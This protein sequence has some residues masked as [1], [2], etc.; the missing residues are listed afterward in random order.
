[1]AS[2][3]LLKVSYKSEKDAA[4]GT[5][6]VD[7]GAGSVQLREVRYSRY[8]VDMTPAFAETDEIRSD[9]QTV[10]AIMT[11]FGAAGQIEAPFAYLIHDDFI[12]AAMLVTSDFQAGVLLAALT[13]LTFAAAGNTITRASGDFVAAGIVAGGFIRITGAA[14]A[15]NNSVW[16]MT[17]VTTTVITVSGGTLVN[18]SAG[19]SVVIKQSQDIKPGTTIHSMMFEAQFTDLS[20]EYAVAT[21]MMV[22]RWALSVPTNGLIK[23]TFDTLGKTVASAS[24]TTGTGAIIAAPTSVQFSS[25]NNIDKVCVAGAVV[26]LTAVQF[27]LDNRLRRHLAIGTLGPIDLGMG[28][29]GLEGS[30][31][32][33]Y[34]SKADWD[35]AKAKTDSSLWLSFVDAANDRYVIEFPAIVYTSATRTAGG[36]DSDAVATIGFRA[37]RST[38]SYDLTMMRFSKIAP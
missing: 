34:A 31:E 32:A 28:S 3:A 2:G 29:I 1:M 18:E 9:R 11:D 27:T 24:A 23:Q 25:V 15:G 4:G 26:S 30:F 17:N 13:N 7:P 12:R 22:S 8:G 33:Y 38:A 37:K 6:G 35:K 16:K 21:G 5:Y 10:D 14:Q 20:N 19:A 36:K